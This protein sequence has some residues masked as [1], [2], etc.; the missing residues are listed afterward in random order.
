[1]AALLLY[2]ATT[3]VLIAC[4]RRFVQPMSR[5]AAIVLVLL[6]LCF[7]GRALLT[8]KVYAPIDLPFMS[9]PLNA[10]AAEFGVP[11]VHN[12]TLSDLYCQ[13]I[14]WRSAVRTAIASGQWPLLNP[15]MLC[16]DILAAAAQSAPYDPLNLLG[17][18][19]PLPPSLTFAAAMT[20]FLA[21][22]GA[23]VFMR[24]LGC[25]EL[26]ALVTAAGWMFSG[27]MAYFVGWPLARSWAYLPMM[28]FAVRLT[29]REASIRGGVILL[30]ALT[31][32]ILS[33]H[34]ESLLHV[35]AVG[36]AYGLFE[37]ATTRKRIGRVIAIACVAGVVA[38]LLT[39]IFLLPFLEASQQTLE[40]RTRVDRSSMPLP[41][42]PE[43]IQRRAANTVFPFW[44]GQPWRDSFTPEF[45]ALTARNGSIVLSLAIATLFVARRRKETWFF[46]GLTLVCLCAAFDAP[47]V[48]NLLHKLPLFNMALNERLAF[49]ASCAMSILAG[50]TIDALAGS[51]GVSPA[52]SARNSTADGTSALPAAIIAAV[53]ALA[54]ALGTYAVWTHEINVGVD[55]NV[56]RIVAFAELLP[57][58]VVAILLFA[59]TPLRIALPVVLML[60]LG[61]RIVEDGSIYPSLPQHDFYPKIPL[62]RA[63]PTDSKE[64]FRVAGEHFVLI[65][66]SAAIYQLED[67][68]GYEAMTFARLADT[69]PIWS[70]PQPI[71]FNAIGDLQPPFL[72]FLNIKYAIVPMPVKVTEG[73]RELMKDRSAKLYENTR[74]LPRA[75]VPR[76][77]RYERSGGPI[78]KAMTEANDFSDMAWVEAPEL[79]PHDIANGPATLTL[80]KDGFGLS[81][82]AVM[83]GD[84]WVVAS[85][86]AWKGW[87]AYIDGRRVQTRFANHAFLGV[88]VPKGRHIVKLQYLPE[89]FTRGRNISFTTLGAL[90]AAAIFPSARRRFQKPRAVRV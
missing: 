22:F 13:I 83:S 29:V 9:E 1:M 43:R 78:V 17:M 62:I 88:F 71:S 87:R 25:G 7:T 48:S 8:G 67:P 24:S 28:F 64:P 19:I 59:R 61:Q 40:I 15:F 90:I 73:W 3:I 84:G 82:D 37:I 46:F 12:G 36:A 72:S 60:I 70:I 11:K 35:T 18:L 85:Q 33:G 21:G 23:F 58:A 50:L 68:R 32:L 2:L 44:G 45:E 75:F 65:P 39:A 63:I 76:R 57:L 6:P 54:L 34:P 49:A 53:I 16:G 30:I 77:I 20:F 10:Y 86:S 55:P 27:S 81:I 5:T 47:P 79:P 74:V 14:P 52:R 89:S 80:H 56:I 41:F 66:D 26:A 51:A 42:M 4:W 31:L 38:L 69:Y